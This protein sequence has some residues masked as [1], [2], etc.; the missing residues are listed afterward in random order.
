MGE[1]VGRGGLIIVFQD[2]IF[3]GEKFRLHWFINK[4]L[5]PRTFCQATKQTLPH[6]GDERTAQEAAYWV[7]RLTTQLL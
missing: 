1:L 7:S 3:G 5:A 2:E 4:L 6:P